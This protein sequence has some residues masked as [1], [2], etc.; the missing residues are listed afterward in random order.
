MPGFPQP[1]GTGRIPVGEEPVFILPD[2]R[3]QR[4]YVFSKLSDTITVL[5]LVNQRLVATIRMD[6]GPIR[7]D[8]ITLNPS[9]LLMSYG[10]Y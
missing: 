10:S 7:A 9:S 3:S 8:C 5:D 4:A 6:S 2:R 1:D